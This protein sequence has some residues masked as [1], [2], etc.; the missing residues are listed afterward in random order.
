MKCPVCKI[1]LN[2]KSIGDVEVD[3]CSKCGGMWFEEDELRRAKD[4]SEADLNWM[5]FEIWKNKDKFKAESRNLSCPKCS[6]ILVAV[7]YAD[8]KTEIDYC[9][10]CKGVWLDQGELKKIIDALNEE[11]NAK[12]FP[13]Y[14]KSSLQEA[15]EIVTGPE[16]FISEWKD[17]MTVLRMMQYRLFAENPKLLNAVIEIQKAN[18]IK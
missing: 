16:S 4:A 1:E 15:K 11:L 7:N 9:A 10:N 18:P 17:F 3:E 8:T 2:K 14:I 5:D 6:Q 13:D 12:S